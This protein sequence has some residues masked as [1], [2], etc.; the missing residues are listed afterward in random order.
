MEKGGA[1]VVSDTQ[2][3]ISKAMD[4]PADS[5]T[6]TPLISDTTTKHKNTDLHNEDY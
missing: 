5:R 1:L 3:Y 4:L 2:D 6:Y